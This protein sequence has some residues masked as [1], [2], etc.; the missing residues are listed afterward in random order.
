MQAKTLAEMQE[1]VAIASPIMDSIRAFLINQVPD[2]RIDI[3]S[4]VAWTWAI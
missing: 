1:W 3:D 4:T 2:G